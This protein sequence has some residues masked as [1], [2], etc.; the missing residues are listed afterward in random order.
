MQMSSFVSP[1]NFIKMWDFAT[2]EPHSFFMI[3]FDAAEP[4]FRFRKRFDMLI[5]APQDKKAAGD[6]SDDGGPVAS[7][8]TE[9][10]LPAPKEHGSPERRGRKRRGKPQGT[11]DNNPR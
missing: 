6:S 10:V 7:Q 11:Y 3:D 2:D 9:P 5:I 1:E 4:E 8:P